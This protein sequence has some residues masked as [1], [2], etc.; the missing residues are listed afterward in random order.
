MKVA[1]GQRVQRGPWGGGNRFVVALATALEE[2]GD[3][4]VFDLA[5]GDVDLIVLT[6]P[7][8]RN[9]AVAFTPGRVLRYLLW[10]NRRAVVV[11]R[12]NE[13]DERKGTHTINMRLRLANHAA[14][15]TVFIGSWLRDLGVWR[16]RT[17]SSVILNGA[18]P[19]L[20]NAEDRRPWD[21]A[22]P[23]SIV[24]HHWGGHWLKGFDVYGR[25]DAM[26][27]EDAWKERLR[28]TYVGSLPAGFSFA[29]ARQ[30]PPLDGPDLA[31]E[32]RRHHVYLTA[33]INEPAGMHHIEGALSGL[34]LLF[35]DSGALPEYCAGYGESFAG[36]DDFTAAVERMIRNHG[37]WARAM[38]GYPNTAGKMCGNYLALFDDLMARR[39]D[40]LARRRLWR[41]PVAVALNQFPW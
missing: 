1:L 12:V 9:P 29:H 37:K 2:R 11:H 14:D 36:P 23:L 19:G 15:H 27:G 41:R 6:D 4:V 8:A 31:N 16:R 22:Q 34:P 33:S 10:R 18:D 25:L 5:D 13:C 38:D 17:P 30:V 26:L 24:T 7:R 21:R 32:L 20:F 28:F 3:S 40:I 39:D 35:R